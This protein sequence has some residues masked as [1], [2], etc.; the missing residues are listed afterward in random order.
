MRSLRD[1]LCIDEKKILFEEG[2]EIE[3]PLP[4]YE[5]VRCNSFFLVLLDIRGGVRF[6]EN[7]FAISFDGE[8]LWQVEPHPW[9]QT[10]N[11]GY[12]QVIPQGNNA[13][14]LLQTWDA[15]VRV[16]AASGKVLEVQA[17]R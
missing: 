8:L 1:F 13:E 15:R 5:V 6:P 9:L 7:A 10:E 4:I 11:D 12:W 14:V 2:H 3:L 17:Y 16:D